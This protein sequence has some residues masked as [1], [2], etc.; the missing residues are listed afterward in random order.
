[1]T[2]FEHSLVILAVCAVAASCQTNSI[3]KQ[4]A[5]L[6]MT[7]SVVAQRQ[8]QSKRFETPDEQFVL[9]GCAGV[10]QDLG[11]LATVESRGDGFAICGLSCPLAASA[12]HHPEVCEL[13]ESLLSELVGAPV[14]ERCVRG[15]TPRCMFEIGMRPAA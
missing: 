1:M 7:S 4:T 5:A 8:I 12:S 15:E 9:R 13:A 10:L 6:S 11:G 3:E 14:R 2:R